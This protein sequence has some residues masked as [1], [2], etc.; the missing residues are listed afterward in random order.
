[1]FVCNFESAPIKIELIDKVM[2]LILLDH[3]PVALESP[4]VSQQAKPQLKIDTALLLK[5][6]EKY[7]AAKYKKMVVGFNEFK[8]ITRKVN[9]PDDKLLAQFVSRLPENKFELEINSVCEC[10]AYFA[11]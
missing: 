8:R 4:E 10:L 2:H 11:Q 6:K 7:E 5:Q 1:M 3:N 9:I